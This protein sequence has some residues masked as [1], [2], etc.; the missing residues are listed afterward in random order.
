MAKWSRDAMVDL[1]QY[2][3]YH[4]RSGKANVRCQGYGL[5][6]GCGGRDLAVYKVRLGTGETAN[7]CRACRKSVQRGYKG[8][9][10]YRRIHRRK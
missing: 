10:E 1:P 6:Q 7:L 2:L 4:K 8:R 9:I 5:P 3:G